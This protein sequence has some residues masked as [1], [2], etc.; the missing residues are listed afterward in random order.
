[1]LIGFTQHEQKATLG[2]LVL[3]VLSPPVAVTG[4]V[5]YHWMHTPSTAYAVPLPL[6]GRRE[7]ALLT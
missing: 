2:P 4:G 3:R 5:S 1:M 7:G 6:L